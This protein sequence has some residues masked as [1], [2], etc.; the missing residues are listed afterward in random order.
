MVTI[1]LTARQQAELGQSSTPIDILCGRLR[2]QALADQ[3][4]ERDWL[5]DDILPP[6]HADRLSFE[7]LRE[8]KQGGKKSWKGIMV[9]E[10]PDTLSCRS[11][12]IVGF[13]FSPQYQQ[14][15]PIVEWLNGLISLSHPE[16]LVLQ[17]QQLSLF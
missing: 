8:I 17:R 5:K 2:R 12:K 9:I 1:V 15:L 6:D 10:F 13:K 16:V 7:S 3:Q 4:W 11:G 14:E